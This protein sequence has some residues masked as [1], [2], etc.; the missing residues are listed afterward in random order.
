M[1]MA[2]SFHLKTNSLWTTLYI[3]MQLLIVIKRSRWRY[4]PTHQF[5]FDAFDGFLL[6]ADSSLVRF[7]SWT[8]DELYR[9]NR[10]SRK[11][12]RNLKGQR[13]IQERRPQRQTG[14]LHLQSQLQYGTCLRSNDYEH[15]CLY[16][17]EKPS[18]TSKPRAVA[19]PAPVPLAAK[20]RSTSRAKKANPKRQTKSGKR[21]A[22]TEINRSTPATKEQQTSAFDDMIPAVEK[23]S[24]PRPLSAAAGTWEK[25][26]LQELSW[27]WCN[28]LL[29]SQAS[30]KASWESGRAQIG[31]KE[32]LQ[33]FRPL[34]KHPV[35]EKVRHESKLESSSEGLKFYD[36][37][38]DDGPDS[39]QNFRAYRFRWR[40]SPQRLNDKAV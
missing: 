14:S 31:A 23:S 39:S 8:H 21:R 20:K 27:A 26:M 24:A 25:A 2:W 16:C 33:Y 35:V 15:W 3:P 29:C 40:I 38:A 19:K 13:N 5:S 4:V 36:L 37:V 34:R 1:P 12:H 30:S 17:Q 10:L 9:Q 6:V 32:K 18:T 11:K 22:L 28:V 7:F